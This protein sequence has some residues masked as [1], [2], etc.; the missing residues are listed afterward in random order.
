[1]SYLV[2]ATSGD[3]FVEANPTSPSAIAI[4]EYHWQIPKW[5]EFLATTHPTPTSLA[6][7]MASRML[8]KTTT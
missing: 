5:L 4:S 7:L 2:G 1:M 6:F 3:V 8:G